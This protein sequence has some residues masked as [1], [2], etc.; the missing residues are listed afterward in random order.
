[1]NNI[2]VLK[3]FIEVRTFKY[4][5][6]IEINLEGNDVLKK[7]G[8]RDIYN[9]WMNPNYEDYNRMLNK[10]VNESITHRTKKR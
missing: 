1:M 8:C 6:F 9:K 10:S 2:K 7:K 4:Q 3:K 5:G